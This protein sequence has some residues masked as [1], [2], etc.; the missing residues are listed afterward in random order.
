M[1][2]PALPLSTKIVSIQNRNTPVIIFFQLPLLLSGIF[3][4]THPTVIKFFN[5]SSTREK[6]NVSL[7]LFSKI[8]YP[9]LSIQHQIKTTEDMVTTSNTSNHQ[10]KVKLNWKVSAAL[11]KMGKKKVYIQ[12]RVSYSLMVKFWAQTS[13]G[14]WSL[15][16][17]T[18]IW[19]TWLI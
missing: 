4:P 6:K 15:T 14:L 17:Q 7:L 19:I 12:I 11:R 10:C 3:Y 8:F 16:N 13:A 2:W 5:F 1:Y 9:P 18:L